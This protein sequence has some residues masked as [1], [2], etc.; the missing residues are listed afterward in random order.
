MKNMTTGPRN[1]KLRG[2]FLFAFTTL[3]VCALAQVRHEGF[4]FVDHIDLKKID[5]TFNDTLLTSY[6]YADSI[7]KPVLFP[8][9]T[10]SGI[11]VTRGYPL[12]PREGE[13]VDHPHHVGL[14]LNYESVNGLDFWNNSTAIP[15]DKREHYGSIVHDGVVKTIPEKKHAILEVTARWIDH[16]DNILLRETTLYKFTVLGSSFIIDR[17]TT[18][19][20]LDID[21]SMKDVK[22]GLLGIRV[23]RELEQPSTEPGKF[24]DDK[25]N[26]TS[27]PVINNDG[28]SGEYL[29]SEGK[30][31]D[32]VW[33]T[34]GRWVSLRG[35]VDNDPVSVTIFDHP[36]NPGYPSYWHARGYGLFA[37]NPLG[38]E[39]FSKG[40]EKLN[41]SIRKGASAT[42]VYRVVIHEGKELTTDE[43]EQFA[44][45]FQMP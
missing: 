25:G 34:R 18:L 29:S 26:V 31:G 5:V 3:S 42:F 4:H 32:E 16:Q 41:F 1:Q 40:K 27:V 37:I 17:K 7:M 19:N 2:L 44:K 35:Q 21:V 45:S 36:S 43:I 24:L 39:I 15:Y 8:I 20:T 12:A 22:D 11:T 30:K 23:R 10:R 38:Q 14:W 13:R 33:G 6:N 28:V 9:H